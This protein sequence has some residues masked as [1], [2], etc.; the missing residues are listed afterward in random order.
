MNRHQGEAAQVFYL[1]SR[2]GEN[3]WLGC[4]G[5]L[6]A[7]THEVYGEL[8]VWTQ[9]DPPFHIY[10]I[11]IELTRSFWPAR[12]YARVPLWIDTERGLR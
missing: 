6:L 9:G 2:D 7:T 8:P 4:A 12:R 3:R 5:M 11:V 10:R 1:V